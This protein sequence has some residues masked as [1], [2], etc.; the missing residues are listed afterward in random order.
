MSHDADLSRWLASRSDRFY[1]KLVAVALAAP[2]TKA[3][4]VTRVH[5][6]RLNLRT[7]FQRIIE[8]AGVAAWPRLFHNLRASCATDWDDRFPNHVAAKWL[9]HSVTIGATH[10]L[11]MRDEHF[12]AAT[13]RKRGAPSGACAVQIEAQHAVA[14]DGTDSRDSSEVAGGDGVVQRG[15]KRSNAPRLLA[16]RS[17]DPKGV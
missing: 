12:D 4:V 10:Y 11:Q 14:S 13:G 3:A 15:A 17:S 7:Q 2:R 6:P 8:R 5:D 9:G 1:Q 16:G